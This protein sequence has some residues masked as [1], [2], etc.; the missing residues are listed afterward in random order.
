MGNEPTVK[1]Q[2]QRAETTVQRM[3]RNQKNQLPSVI[4]RFGLTAE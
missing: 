1:G 4:A 2:E 3:R